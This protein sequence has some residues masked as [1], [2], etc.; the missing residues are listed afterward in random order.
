MLN[1]VP[2]VCRAKIKKNCGTE[3]ELMQKRKIVLFTLMNNDILQGHNHTLNQRPQP[4]SNH[5]L[6]S[7]QNGSIVYLLQLQYDLIWSCH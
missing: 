1:T 6:P 3:N 5:S 4:H 7:L 2:E